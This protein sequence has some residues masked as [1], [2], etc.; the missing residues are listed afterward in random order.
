MTESAES[1][2][3]HPNP[4]SKD[5]SAPGLTAAERLRH[6]VD[7][8][9][10]TVEVQEHFNDI[11]W[12]IRGLALTVATFALGAA[13]VV[14][15]DEAKVGP[16][17]LGTLVVL[18]GLLLWYAFYFVDRWWYHPL[19][20]AAV[21]QGTDLEKEIQ[22]LLPAAGMTATITAGSAYSPGLIVRTLSRKTAMHS[23]DKLA[24]FYKVGAIAF[25]AAAVG[26]Q[27][28]GDASHSVVPQPNTDEPSSSSVVVP[29][30]SS[31]GPEPPPTGTPTP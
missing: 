30:P 4:T 27:F 15:R 11:E 28:A 21:S 1:A 26:F 19:L 2:C 3:E 22:K 25:L 13:G 17:S 6:Y 12:R 18:L 10:T 5:D 7:L 9:K 24:W 31:S 8:Y 16:V 14:A 29:G 20:K 23:D